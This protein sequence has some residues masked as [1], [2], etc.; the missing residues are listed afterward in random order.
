MPG[1]Y[2]ETDIKKGSD[3]KIESIRVE[4]LDLI[5]RKPSDKHTH[6]F[7]LWLAQGVMLAFILGTWSALSSMRWAGYIGPFLLWGVVS[8][9]WWVFW[10][11][12]KRPDKSPRSV[13][14]YA[15]GRIETG[16]KPDTISATARGH[17]LNL[18]NVVHFESSSSQQWGGLQNAGTYLVPHEARDIY[19]LLS[20]GSRVVVGHSTVLLEMVSQITVQLNTALHQVRGGNY[21]PW[22]T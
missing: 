19:A 22:R 21:N 17:L 14:F 6:Y 4:W 20:D 18:K 12:E 8:L 5:S 2:A 11:T 3:G 16:E 9:L 15:D 7:L 1:L 13:T 10:L